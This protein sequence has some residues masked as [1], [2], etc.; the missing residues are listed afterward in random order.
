MFGIALDTRVADFKRVARMP[1]AMAVGIAAQFIVLP[2]VTFGLT[3]CSS[4]GP[5]SRWA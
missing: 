2:A 1:L 4:P 5:A 3:C